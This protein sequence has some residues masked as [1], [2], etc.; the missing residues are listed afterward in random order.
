VALLD[1]NVI[2]RSENPQGTRGHTLFTARA[3]VDI[4]FAQFQD[5]GRTDALR[6]LDNTVFDAGGNVTHLGTNQV[7]RYAVHLHH[8]MGPENPANEGY[9]F[10]FVGN[11]IERSLKW[12]VAVHDTSFGLVDRNVVYDAQG[13]GFV[14]EDG[15][16]VE[17]TF[18]S[19][20]AIRIQG[21]HEDGKSGTL[22]GDYGRGG[23]GFWFRRGGNE[24]TGNVAA[25][26]TFAGFVFD[27]YYSGAITLPAFRGAEKHEEGQGVATELSPITWFSNNETYG[28]SRHGLW[29]A[30]I[31]GNNLFD[32]HPLAYFQDF[33][34]WHT[35]HSG[36]LAYHTNNMTFERLLILGDLSAQDRNDSGPVGMHLA[37]YENFNLAVRNSRIEGVRFGIVAPTNDATKAGVERP[38]VIL[39]SILRN[40]FNIIVTPPRDNRPSAGSVLEVRDV[41]FTLVSQLP[42]GPAAP[43]LVLAPANIFMTT[44]G[45]NVQWTQ[46]SI[47]RVYNY[48]RVAGDDFQVFYHEQAPS[49]VLPQTSLSAL[50]GRDSHEVGSPAAGLTNAE[51][52][53]FYGIAMGGMP[54][55][56]GASASRSEIS[57]LVAPIQNLSA[58]PPT[59]ILVTPWN[60]AAVPAGEPVRVRYNVVG[61]LPQGGHVYFRLDGAAPVGGFKDNSIFNLAPGV[62]WLTVYVGDDNGDPLDGATVMTYTFTVIA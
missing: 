57:G 9:Q 7:G 37:T 33:R 15:S 56:A 44:V 34:L 19:N 48:N 43:S 52:W 38:T 30:Y 40:Y 6:P 29:A 10:E 27:G 25:D 24:I 21:T 58:L 14:T 31:A 3:D 42:T 22:E 20:I 35:Y 5:L 59:V 11:T 39:S 50:W 12:A 47:V 8:V 60:G 62:H 2:I 53:A 45:A 51:S 26:A 13:A 4:R 54:A 49:F 17:N 41:L 16:E 28:M 1:R 61:L 46:T 55:P 23:V 36:V 32:N 18:S